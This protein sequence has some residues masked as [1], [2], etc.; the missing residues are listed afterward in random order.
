MYYSRV[1]TFPP[2]QFFKDCI[3]LFLERGEGREKEKER[4]NNVWLPFKCPPL[5]TW[6]TIPACA[7]TGNSANDPFVHRLAL[8]PLRHTSQGRQNNFE[9][10]EQAERL[11]FLNFKTY[12]NGMVFTTV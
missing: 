8:S 11:T 7:L 12:Y 2:K 4:N 9:K 10:E 3:Y 1:K 5:G 6:P